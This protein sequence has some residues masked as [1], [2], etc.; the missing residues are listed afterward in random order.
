MFHEQM[1]K[2]QV[3]TKGDSTGWAVFEEGRLQGV[4]TW[5]GHQHS[6]GR[7]HLLSDMD[8]QAIA[9]NTS[10]YTIIKGR[11]IVIQTGASGS[12][13]RAF[14]PHANNPYWASKYN[15]NYGVNI[16]TFGVA[17]DPRRADCVFKDINGTN[18]DSWTMF[19][20]R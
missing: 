12:S 1:A 11:S 20:N 10:P 8:T 6:Y 19:S 16:C 2:M 5:N 14:G 15:A 3:G 18:R 7:T 9:D 4:T 13:L 17:G